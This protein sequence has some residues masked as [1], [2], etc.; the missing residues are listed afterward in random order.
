[1]KKQRRW[2]SAAI[3]G[4]ALVAASCGIGGP[5][6]VS[7]GGSITSAINPASK[8]PGSFSFNTRA[9]C[10]DGSPTCSFEGITLS[11]VTGTLKDP[12][13]STAFPKGV[14]IN[15]SGKLEGGRL[16]G[17]AIGG[18]GYCDTEEGA[19]A[20]AGVA[21]GPEPLCYAGLVTYRSSDLKN[22][23][24]INGD[25]ECDFG[26][27]ELIGFLGPTK[28]TSIS[29][30]GLAFLVDSNDNATPDK[31][32]YVGFVSLCGPYSNLTASGVNGGD[33]YSYATC[34]DGWVDFDGS[35]TVAPVTPGPDEIECVT[36]LR[37]GNLKITPVSTTSTTPSST[38]STPAI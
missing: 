12:G 22:Y 28:K 37:S 10:T 17:F 8:Q 35:M 32:D 14:S 15:F 33:P 23:P 21:T 18:G 36:P 16:R 5:A 24:N 27:D 34:T 26:V 29:G 6:D 20:V 2:L 30:I 19:P 38:T 4:F 11:A 3:L 1:M 25:A 31:G 9:L 7:G 13:T